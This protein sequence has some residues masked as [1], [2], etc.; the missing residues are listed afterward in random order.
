METDRSVR[1]LTA[2]EQ[3]ASTARVLNLLATHRKYPNDP[4]LAQ[5]PMFRNVLL[6]RSI[7]LKHRLR[8][9]EYAY[10]TSPRP[11]ATKVLIPID[12]SDLKAGARAFFVG[13]KDFD[14]VAE[15]AF[16]ADLRHGSPDRRMLELLD[17]LP[18]FDPF[19]L[20]EHL[21]ANGIEPARTYFGISDADV[22]RM[23]DFVREEIMSLVTLLAGDAGGAHAHASRMVEKLLSNAP[24]SGF[25]PL[26]A[27][28]KLSDQEYLDGVFSWRGFLYY[29]WVLGDLIK[30]MSQVMT[31]IGQIQGRGPR[32]VDALA[33]IPGAKARIHNAM[34]R[35]V[36]NAQA[37]LDVYN[38]AYASLTDDG[39]P[40]GFRDFLLAAPAMFASLGEQLGAIQHVISFW[41]YRMPPGRP[42]LIGWEELM[43]VFLDFEDG[44]ALPALEAGHALA[45]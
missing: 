15:V 18:S 26:K 41:R 7:I 3:S 11:T 36:V 43:D 38:R 19:L 13:Q 16:G 27:T 45:V 8:P 12:G 37:M 5:A 25:E 33:Y 32:T 14:S 21:R 24:D 44:L 6:D 42:A 17:G 40:M 35:T 10:F 29:K 2:L 9:H 39:K 31:E 28:L 23:F 22:Q 20:R 4:D 30:P 34:G 1:R